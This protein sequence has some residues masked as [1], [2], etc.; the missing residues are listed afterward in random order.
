MCRPILLSF[1]AWFTWCSLAAAQPSA[2]KSP[3]VKVV[4]ALMALLEEPEMD[5]EAAKQLLDGLHGQ[6]LCMAH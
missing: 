5:S 4:R 3:P 6:A 1:L 2:G